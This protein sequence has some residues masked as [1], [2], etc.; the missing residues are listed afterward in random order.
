[1]YVGPYLVGQPQL[2]LV[3][4][5]AQGVA[6]YLLAADDTRAFERWAEEHWWPI[7]RRQYPL[8]DG[9]TPDD[10]MV[11]LIHAPPRAPDAVVTAYPAHMHIDL[12]ARVRGHGFGRA[13]VERLLATLRERGS[14]GVH[15]DV[16]SDNPDA[17]AFY[18]HLG[19]DDV[20]HGPTSLL[21]GM[22]LR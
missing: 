8:N 18:R 13:L 5:D 3:V 1:V 7:L 10:E 12:L 15:L 11:R 14:P 4:A 22:R 17:I 2:A 6:G 9:D 21:M 20:E 16:A 19:F